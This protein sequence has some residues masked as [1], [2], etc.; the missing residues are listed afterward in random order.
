MRI[1][2]PA[3]RRASLMIFRRGSEADHA[4]A[5][6]LRAQREEIARRIF[7]AIMTGAA[8]EVHQRYNDGHTMS[9]YH[10]STRGDF[11]QETWLTRG[12]HTGGEWE[13]SGHHDV[14]SPADIDIKAGHY[15][16]ITA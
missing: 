7:D 16:T 1:Y 14:H 4:R 8:M 6:A 5:D 3:A 10:R 12:P 2:I 11:I 15:L 13:P 9:V